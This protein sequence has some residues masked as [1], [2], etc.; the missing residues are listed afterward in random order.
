M[1][2]YNFFDSNEK[3][4]LLVFFMA[5]LI[6]SIYAIYKANN[7]NS[8]PVDYINIQPFLTDPENTLTVNNSNIFLETNY[9]LKVGYY[10]LSLGLY[11]QST[12]TPGGSEVLVSF[13]T[14]STF[15][16][17]PTEFILSNTTVGQTSFYPGDVINNLSG[18]FYNKEENARVVFAIFLLHASETIEYALSVLNGISI[19]YLGTDKNNLR[20]LTASRNRNIKENNLVKEI[21]KQLQTKKLNN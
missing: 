16:D 11:F 21:R 1:N 15:M 10:Q 2:S 7:S 4:Y 13:L 20:N 17:N 8:Y 18:I 19:Q 3:F 9:S 12:G 5:T 14:S 6:L